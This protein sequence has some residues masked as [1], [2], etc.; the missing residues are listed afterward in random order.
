M[1]PSIGAGS[2]S[3]LSIVLTLAVIGF[4][5]YRQ[6][7]PRRLSSRSLIIVPLVLLFFIARS[8]PLLH[9]TST[10]VV[11]IGIDVVVSLTAGLLAARQLHVYASPDTGR[12]MAGGSW[13]Y[14]LWWLGAFVVKA[15]VIVAMGETAQS[16][17][18]VEVLVPLFL[19]VVTR[20]GYLYWKATRL[21]LALH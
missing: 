20:N 16:M 6:V 9:L 2:A 5:I 11:E 3:I 12:A 15:A 10:K 13:T 14:F 1:A 19:L 17:S 18:T 21:G 4:M 7:R 8:S